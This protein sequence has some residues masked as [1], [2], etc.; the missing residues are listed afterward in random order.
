[1]RL[2]AAAAATSP[3]EPPGAIPTPPPAPPPQPNGTRGNT[4]KR[5]KKRRWRFRYADNDALANALTDYFSYCEAPSFEQYRL[6]YEALPCKPDAPWID[7]PL[8]RRQAFATTVLSDYTA[9]VDPGARQALLQ[10]LLYVAQGCFR[11]I[12]FNFDL[13]QASDP[14]SSHSSNQPTVHSDPLHH[15]WIRQNIDLLQDAG[16]LGVIH[17]AWCQLA[18]AML[19]QHIGDEANIEEQGEAVYAHLAPDHAASPLNPDAEGEFALL[20]DLLFMMLEVKWDDQAFTLDVLKLSPPLTLL[21]LLLTPTM[22]QWYTDHLLL[23]K[24]LLLTRRCLITTMG[25]TDQETLQ[26]A[27]KATMGCAGTPASGCKCDATQAYQFYLVE[28]QR[29]PAFYDT[30]RE[31]LNYLTNLLRDTDAPLV[32]QGAANQPMEGLY[33]PRAH[34]YRVLAQDQT[35]MN[36]ESNVRLPPVTLS[37]P[38]VIPSW[39]QK[40][41][42][43]YQRS[44]YISPT[45]RQRFEVCRDYSL[46]APSSYWQLYGIEAYREWQIVPRPLVSSHVR[47]S[48]G[49][50]HQRTAFGHRLPWTFLYSDLHD[51][52]SAQQFPPT[53]T[54]PA[55]TLLTEIQQLRITLIHECYNTVCPHLPQMARAWHAWA[56]FTCRTTRNPSGKSIVGDQVMYAPKAYTPTPVPMPLLSPTSPFLTSDRTDQD[57]FEPPYH[58]TPTLAR[59][60]RRSLPTLASSDYQSLEGAVASNISSSLPNGLSTHMP[61]PPFTTPASPATPSSSLSLDP[62]LMA[63]LNALGVTAPP[64][65]PM[66]QFVQQRDRRITMMAVV[67]ILM[68]LSKSFKVDHGLRQATLLQQLWDEG[69]TRTF[70]SWIDMVQIRAVVE[71]EKLEDLGFTA[72]CSPQSNLW[73][74]L[75]PWLNGQ[76]TNGTATPTDA[77]S[78]NESESDSDGSST[79]HTFPSS[80]NSEYVSLSDS[81][82]RVSGSGPPHPTV[83]TDQPTVTAIPTLPLVDLGSGEAHRRHRQLI[84]LSISP[85]P[86]QSSEWTAGSSRSG[87][88]TATHRSGASTFASAQAWR[89]L[90]APEGVSSEAL[91]L[92]TPRSPLYLTGQ[93]LAQHM[94]YLQSKE[95]LELRS[96]TE[97]DAG[98]DA[99]SYVSEPMAAATMVGTVPSEYRNGNGG[100][101]TFVPQVLHRHLWCSQYTAVSMLRLIQ[102]MTKQQPKRLERLKT[103]NCL[104]TLQRLANRN[105]HGAKRY[106]YKIVK[107]LVPFLGRDWYF[108]Y[109]PFISGIYTHLP[110]R[111][112]ETWQD[113]YPGTSA[114]IKAQDQRLRQLIAYFNAETVPWYYNH[115]GSYLPTLH[116]SFELW[117]ALVSS[118]P[119]CQ[120]GRMAMEVATPPVKV[121]NNGSY[122]GIASGEREDHVVDSE[123]NPTSDSNDEED[124]LTKASFHPGTDE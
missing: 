122:S 8:S 70:F 100:G 15:Y 14:V 31:P 47:T 12:P 34:M 109:L 76:P 56:Q 121:G 96:A 115:H 13:Y 1:M 93:L 58:P 90:M 18:Q 28:T 27:L 48:A 80:G 104:P 95:P 69:F 103:I 49:S 32:A 73:T 53:A 101:D 77:Y 113:P 21:L 84:P 39:L 107:S 2:H 17:T 37:D 116:Q 51:R 46:V 85:T 98:G 66:A 120:A 20:F 25:G 19:R 86:S 110:P 79:S 97:T 72:F 26:G 7:A 11:S 87:M 118:A 88:T 94:P 117:Q 3:P 6:C 24:Y 91:L 102:A 43:L 63:L 99:M 112:V 44:L 40:A 83:L 89:A 22:H 64:L 123:G 111:L 5:K 4:R 68:V 42:D 59:S 45:Q 114:T 54:P 75:L 55:A 38:S 50:P 33:A 108:R 65:V 29:C 61:I 106:V 81:S 78:S 52:P 23:K 74:V 71:R 10:A 62:Q 57:P 67:G 92:T 16:A 35:I 82:P 30:A 119:N 36:S 60:R 9:A 105:I 41:H 124:E